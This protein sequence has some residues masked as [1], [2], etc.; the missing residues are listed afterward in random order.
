MLKFS[1]MDLGS[2]NAQQQ[3]W[4]R[5]LKNI[6]PQIGNTNYFNLV[7]KDTYIYTVSDGVVLV[8][9]ENAVSLAELNK[10]HDLI[11]HNIQELSGTNFT[12]QFLTKNAITTAKNKKELLSTATTPTFFKDS[13]LEP[14]FTFNNFVVGVSNA[15]AQKAAIAV[16]ENPGVLYNPLFIY[17]DSGLGKTHLL[18]AIGNLIKENSI[19]K[20][21]LCIGSQ[22][23]LQ[24]Y[25][26]FT[27]DAKKSED[28][29]TFLKS[30][31]VLLMDDIQ[32]LNDKRKT[33]EFFF[34]IFQYFIQNDKQ[35]VLTSDRL[36]SEL[37]GIDNRLVSRFMDGLTMQVTKP[38]LE[39]VVTI[40]KKK[41]EFNKF[42]V[43]DF[44]EDAILFI[45]QNFQTNVRELNGA[46]TRILFYNNL[47]QIEH[48]TLE[49][50]Q[51]ILGDLTQNKGST[52]KGAI[53]EQKIL[54][55]VANYYGISI[56]QLTG[57]LRNQKFVI[58]R[59]IAIYLIRDML[60]TPYKKIG[61]LFTNRDHSTIISSIRKVDDALKTDKDYQQVVNELKV[62]LKGTKH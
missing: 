37:E 15:D 35:I 33:L 40:L 50:V 1:N 27:K 52:P 2:L 39:T 16:S 54:S 61:Q 32:M 60:N 3:L 11:E 48:F 12:V 26:T 47:H 58:P 31:D 42:K 49:A 55:T 10:Y 43:A 14:T 24:E 6:Q 41:I 38:D 53:T 22:S 19:G 25:V 45:A 28:L 5:T 30:Y 7:F 44:D 13:R 20:K 59:H 51:E 23:F 34:E 4:D 21:V 56:K 46:F 8:A 62:R 36:P 18:N 9:C 29:Q 17:G 57:T